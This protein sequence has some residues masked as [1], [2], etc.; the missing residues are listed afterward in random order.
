MAQAAGPDTSDILII[1]RCD[2]EHSRQI[3]TAVGAA[4]GPSNVL[5]QLDDLELDRLVAASRR[6]LQ[7]R[8]RPMPVRPRFDRRPI[9]VQPSGPRSH[10]LQG[11]NSG[12]R[13][14]GLEGWEHRIHLTL[15]RRLEYVILPDCYAARPIK[16]R[17]MVCRCGGGHGAARFEGKSPGRRNMGMHAVRGRGDGPNW[18]KARPAMVSLERFNCPIKFGG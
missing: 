4:E 6:E 17:D 16:S 5:R 12:R 18:R 13:G 7:R 9:S 11:T 1:V 14:S 2:R 8:S 10:Q 15:S 3:V